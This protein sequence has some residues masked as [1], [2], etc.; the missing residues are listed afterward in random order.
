MFDFSVVRRL[1]RNVDFNFAIDNLFNRSY[2]ETQNFIESRP[3]AGGLAA[4][5]IHATV[6]V[7]ITARFGG[8]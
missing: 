6:T 1:R 8:K 2:Y 5:G 3:F 7:G 4:Y